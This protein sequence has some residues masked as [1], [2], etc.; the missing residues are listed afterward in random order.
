MTKTSQKPKGNI[1]SKIVGFFLFLTIIAIFVILHFALSKATIIVNSQTETKE[2]SILVEMRSESETD[3]EADVL[4]GKIINTEVE[5]EV[6]VPSGQETVES[7]KAGGY[8]TIYN[9]YSQDQIL[10]ATTRLLTPD[11]K[12][13]R[14]ADRVSIP[15]GG[16]VSVW[17]EADEVGAEMVTEPTTFVIPGLWEG[18]QDKIY[19]E[20][21][22]GM[23]LETLPRYTVTQETID[24][25]KEKIKVQA[26]EQALLTINNLL[27]ESL[28]IGPERLSFNFETI[29]GSELGD[30]SAETTIKQKVTANGLVFAQDDLY[31]IAKTKFAKEMDTDESLINF[32]ETDTYI[33]V[34]IDL[35]NERAIIEV[36][37]SSV[38]S[39]NPDVLNIEKEKLIGLDEAGVREYLRQLKIEDVQVKFFPAWV[40]K[41]PNIKDKII[42]E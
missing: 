4:I 37:L 40:K 10:I 25:V 18:L 5:L 24:Q 21:K 22:E 27:P 38:V 42:I 13:F 19:A 31:N 2:G 15:A 16:E 36:S 32:D 17:A 23:K 7:E 29:S 35:E 30:S 3:L 6:S 8:V 12:L 14:I 11:E 41:V 39:A 9:N 28:A 26:T 34:E 1:Y 20:T 33:I